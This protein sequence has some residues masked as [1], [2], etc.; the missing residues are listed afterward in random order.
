MT[1]IA[2]RGGWVVGWI[3][4]RHQVLEGGTVVVEKDR[5]IFVGFPDD[6]A[7]PPADRV[8]SQKANW[9]LLV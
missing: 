1:K 4:G 8:I 3:D 2:F 9:F 7:C 5:I 6:P